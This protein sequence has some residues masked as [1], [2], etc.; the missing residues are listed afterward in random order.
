[1][2]ATDEKTALVRTGQGKKP[3][4]KSSILLYRHILEEMFMWDR[5]TEYIKLEKFRLCFKFGILLAIR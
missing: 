5:G 3:A 4:G 2:N 1:M